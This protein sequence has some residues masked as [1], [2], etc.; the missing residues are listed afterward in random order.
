MTAAV[1]VAGGRGVR[2]G[3]DLPKQFAEVLAK[4]HLGLYAR[5]LRTPAGD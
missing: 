2:M 1:V 3:L 4:P 5:I